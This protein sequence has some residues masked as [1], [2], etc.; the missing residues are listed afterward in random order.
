MNSSR[1]C[2]EFC[3]P[4]IIYARYQ[5]SS[6]LSHA[7][8]LHLSMSS[9]HKEHVVCKTTHQ[10][11]LFSWEGQ[12]FC[13]HFFPLMSANQSVNPPLTMLFLVF[14]WCLPFLLNYQMLFLAIRVRTSEHARQMFCERNALVVGLKRK[15]KRAL[16]MRRSQTGRF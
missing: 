7:S 10:A 13:F 11:C 2:L 9:Q 4:G 6:H 15:G 12:P 14:R 5:P 16:W 1:S 3:V 8:D